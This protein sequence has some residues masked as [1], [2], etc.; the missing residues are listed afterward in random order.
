M[1]QTLILSVKPYIFVILI[2]QDPIEFVNFLFKLESN[3]TILIPH[4][5]QIKLHKKYP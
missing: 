2:N 4:Q 3:K 1:L 5:T